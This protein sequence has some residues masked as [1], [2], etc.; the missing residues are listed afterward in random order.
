MGAEYYPNN[1]EGN[2]YI[3]Y[4]SNIPQEVLSHNDRR[5]AKWKISLKR[6]VKV[7]FYTYTGFHVGDIRVT[8]PS[9]I[10]G[11]VW[12]AGDNSRASNNGILF[13]EQ[14]TRHSTIYT[15]TYAR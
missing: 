12:R 2:C 7:S 11:K 9:F 4:G 8:T 3:L 13:M 1:G 14:T 15:K 5:D 6:L 10:K